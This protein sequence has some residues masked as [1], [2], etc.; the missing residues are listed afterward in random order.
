MV[1]WLEGFLALI[2]AGLMILCVALLH[3][4]PFILGVLVIY[5]LLF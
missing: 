1:N 5:W 3:A 2:G 4:L